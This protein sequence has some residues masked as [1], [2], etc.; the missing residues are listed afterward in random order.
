MRI[1]NN[2]DIKEALIGTL[3]ICL[4]IL[5]I[6]P[7]QLCSNLG[8]KC[9][10][11]PQRLVVVRKELNDLLLSFAFIPLNLRK[12][13]HTYLIPYS[14]EWSLKCLDLF[15]YINLSCLRNVCSG[16]VAVIPRRFPPSSNTDGLLTTPVLK[17]ELFCHQWMTWQTFTEQHRTVKRL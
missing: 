7:K 15:F 2:F 17:M 3:K 8:K 5:E 4:D 9:N 14:A 12:S 6:K 10:I 1:Q 13:W 11:Y 16:L